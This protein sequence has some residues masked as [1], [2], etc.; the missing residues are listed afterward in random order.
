MYPVFLK[1]GNITVYTYGVMF[2]LGYLA[3]MFIVVRDAR[4]KGIATEFLYDLFF[5]V[6]IWGIIGAR[7]FYVLLNIRY[8]INSPLELFMLHHGGLVFYGGLIFGIISAVIFLKKRKQPV[9]ST[10]DFITPY[11]PLGHA[12]GRIGCFFNGCCYGRPTDFFLGIT[13]PTSM[14]KVHPTQLYSSAI[15]ILLF[16]VLRYLRAHKRF[17]GQVFLSYLILYALARFILEFFR[18]DNFPVFL[19]LSIAQLISI[20]IIST[21]IFIYSLLR[22]RHRNCLKTIPFS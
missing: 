8:Y 4:Q 10:V 11:L 6:L 14:G 15:L 7:L 18:G 20:M 21:S 22:K 16:L 12:F 5:I 17:N 1:I 19:Q 3:A 2:A 9:L 13:F